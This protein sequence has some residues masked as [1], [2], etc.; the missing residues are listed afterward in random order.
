MALNL[1]IADDSADRPPLQKLDPLQAFLAG[2]AVIAAHPHPAQP[3]RDSHSQRRRDQ[4]FRGDPIRRYQP[5]VLGCRPRHR[6]FV[7]F[8]VIDAITQELYEQHCGWSAS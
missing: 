1:N 7:L 3:L 5:V 6:E 8:E 2:I 4:A